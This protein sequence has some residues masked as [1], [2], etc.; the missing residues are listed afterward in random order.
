MLE[1]ESVGVA[2]FVARIAKDVALHTVP[3]IT[4]PV[5][6][7]ANAFEKSSLSKYR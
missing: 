5:P 1:K 7:L 6:A 4:T 2:R 3:L